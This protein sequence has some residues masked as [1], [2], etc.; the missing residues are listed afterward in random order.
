MTINAVTPLGVTTAANFV[1]T[2]D[3]QDPCAPVTIDSGLTVFTSPALTQNVWQSQSDITWSDT[4]VTHSVNS[5]NCG[6]VTW[7]LT[8]TDTTAIDTS[9]FTATLLTTV[10]ST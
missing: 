3:F 1:F 5:Y 10:G 7:T 2:V 4:L 6:A 8:N 9:V